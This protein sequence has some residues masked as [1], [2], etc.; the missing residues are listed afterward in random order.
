M[1]TSEEFR[2]ATDEAPSEPDLDAPA[3]PDVSGADEADPGDIDT[4]AHAD[5]APADDEA[6][7]A[8]SGDDAAEGDSS[9]VDEA[10]AA[11]DALEG[12]SLEEPDEESGSADG[13]Q[14][15][16]VVGV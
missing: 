6:P 8:P 5:V 2:T 11:F 12:G 7:E 10:S 4:D 9:V 3:G 15:V 1:E 16:E 13:L 14:V